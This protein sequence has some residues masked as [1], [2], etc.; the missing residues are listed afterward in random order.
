V[1]GDPEAPQRIFLAASVLATGVF[2]V[3]EAWLFWR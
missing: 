2:L 3:K 1:I